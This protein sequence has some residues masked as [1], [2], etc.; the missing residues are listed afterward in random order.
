MPFASKSSLI[1]LTQILNRFVPVVAR[2]LALGFAVLAL[3]TA[4]LDMGDYPGSRERYLV[5]GLYLVFALVSFGIGRATKPILKWVL[6][7]L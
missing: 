3:A 5:A 7:R 4:F 1:R 6:R 2:G